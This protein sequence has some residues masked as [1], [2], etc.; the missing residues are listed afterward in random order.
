MET[1]R[2]ALEALWKASE[3]T[4]GVAG[5]LEVL[6]MID[7]RYHASIRDVARMAAPVLRHRLVRTFEAET[8]GRSVE[9]IIE[10]VLESLPVDPE[11]N[12]PL[13]LM[14]DALT[15]EERIR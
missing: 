2:R 13:R 11:R 14:P 7:G 1:G 8:D 9:D 4:R 15:G 10:A 6:A 12:E 3:R 5:A